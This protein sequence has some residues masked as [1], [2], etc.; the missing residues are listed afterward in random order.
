MWKRRLERLGKKGVKGTRVREIEKKARPPRR[1]IPMF[2]VT[3]MEWGGTLPGK[4]RSSRREAQKGRQEGGNEMTHIS[5]ADHEGHGTPDK[6]GWHQ[7]EGGKG[8]PP[9]GK[10]RLSI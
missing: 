7:G 1:K 3:R 10:R 9:R 2:Q 5:L 6:N 8:V 4:V